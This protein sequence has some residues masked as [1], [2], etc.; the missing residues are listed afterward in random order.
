MWVHDAGPE[1]VEKIKTSYRF[2]DVVFGT[3]NI[4]KLAELLYNRFTS[5][6]QIIDI[7]DSTKEVV[8]EL[9]TSRKY[10]F[11]SGVI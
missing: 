10:P 7:W 11:K 5:E 4:F 8:E 6:E 2:V 1:V 9:P 3:F